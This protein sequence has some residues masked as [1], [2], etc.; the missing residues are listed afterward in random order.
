MCGTRTIWLSG[1][2]TTVR[3]E[4]GPDRI[5]RDASPVVRRFIGQPV[6]NLRA[7]INADREV[8]LVTPGR[9]CE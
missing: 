7:W 3:I 1:P 8:E 2:R 4:V 6:D 9:Y 5:I